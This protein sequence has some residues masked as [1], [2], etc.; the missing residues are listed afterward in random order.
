MIKKYKILT[1]VFTL[2]VMT[3][4]SF[5][6]SAEDIE[7]ASFRNVVTGVNTNVSTTNIVTSNL[8]IEKKIGWQKVNGVWY[9][10]DI[11]GM[12]QTG[13]VNDNGTWYYCDKTGAMLRNITIDG[14]SLNSSGALIM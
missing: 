13:W 12:L 8:N 5:S 7:I 10:F 3:L 14:Y 2:A 6:A 1:S 11:N 9:Y 4:M